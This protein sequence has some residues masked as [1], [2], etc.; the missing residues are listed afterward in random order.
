[1]KAPTAPYPPK[2][3]KVKIIKKNKTNKIYYRKKKNTKKTKEWRTRQLPF[4]LAL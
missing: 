1:M 3:I 4:K 2:K